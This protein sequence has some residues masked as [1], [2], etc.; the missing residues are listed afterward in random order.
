VEYISVGF[1]SKIAYT[2]ISGKS[3]DFCREVKTERLRRKC[4]T[5]SR[6]SGYVKYGRTLLTLG[7]SWEKV[8]LKPSIREV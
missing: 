8:K 6:I 3:I 2:E 7:K 5:L 1:S 4:T